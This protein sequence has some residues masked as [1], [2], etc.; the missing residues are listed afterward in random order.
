MRNFL[1]FLFLLPTL[2]FS[3]KPIDYLK[4]ID[5]KIKIT[6]LQKTF[7]GLN[8]KH[9][10]KYNINEQ[11]LN[12]ISSQTGLTSNNLL[13]F[14][15]LLCFI[16]IM[17]GIYVIWVNRKIINIRKENKSLLKEILNTE[18]EFDGTNELS[19]T[20]VKFLFLKIK[21]EE[22]ILILNRLTTAPHDILSVYTQL[23]YRELL[24]EDYP[25]LKKAYLKLEPK[26]ENCRNSYKQLFLHHFLDQSIKDDEIGIDLI[27]Q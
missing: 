18:E 21:R 4:I 11:T 15:F 12:R 14:T 8:Q 13:N 3:Q 24:E 10:Y 5:N 16:A 20:E 17:L 7:T 26:K 2:T 22:T 25:L 9:G 6:K 23:F 1:L 27:N 19:I